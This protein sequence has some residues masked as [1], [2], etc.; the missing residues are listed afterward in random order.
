MV[1]PRHDIFSW[2]STWWKA[3]RPFSFTASL[4]PVLYGAALAGL[5]GQLKLLPLILLANVALHA[6]ANLISD[7]YDYWNE[8]DLPGTSG[9][10]GVI[11]SG[12]LSPSQVYR[13]GW[14]LFLVSFLVAIPLLLIRGLPLFILGIIG[15]AGSYFY[16]GGPKGY[17]YLGLGDFF[18]GLFMGPFMVYGSYATL[19]GDFGPI[20]KIALLSLPISFLVVNILHLNNFRDMDTDQGTG[21]TTVAGLLG[22]RG[23]V[24]YSASL[25]V[26]AVILVP[27]FSFLGFLPISSM[28]ACAVIFP[29]IGLIK[30]LMTVTAPLAFALQGTDKAAAKIH[31]LFGILISSS[32]AIFTV[33]K[34]VP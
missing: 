31:V 3:V 28:I 34:K 4:I 6:G 5:A 20:G 8:V 16:C 22:Q 26:G 32:A 25:M 9:S 30:K 14:I 24:L 23:S 29:M 21:V 13:G 18:I 2:A 15:I 33:L 7:A 27:I 1:K 12:V 10:S 17:K 19:T 11:T